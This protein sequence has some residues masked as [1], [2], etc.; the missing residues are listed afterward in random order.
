[1]FFT[2]IGREEKYKAKNLIDVVVYRGSD[3]LYGWVFDGLQALGLKLGAIAL[4]ALP[5]AAGWLV[6]SL[7]LGR[8]QER[9]ATLIDREV[10]KG[11]NGTPSDANLAAETTGAADFGAAD[12]GGP[13]TGE[14][15]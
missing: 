12:D 1:V 2:V 11:Q 8:V 15:A 9:R 14:R 3:A 6:L 10:A 4:V 13:M 5:A 7:V